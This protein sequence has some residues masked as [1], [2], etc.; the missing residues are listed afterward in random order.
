MIHNRIIRRQGGVAILTHTTRT[1]HRTTMVTQLIVIQSRIKNWSLLRGNITLNHHTN[2]IDNSTIIIA[3]I[4]ANGSKHN[5][6]KND[7]LS[8][9]LANNVVNGTL[10]RKLTSNRQIK[11]WVIIRLRTYRRHIRFIAT[12]RT[13]MTNINNLRFT[14]IIIFLNNMNTNRRSHVLRKN[15]NILHL[16]RVNIN[17]LIILGTQGRRGPSGG[18]GRHRRRGS[19]RRGFVTLYR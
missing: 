6:T 4:I 2:N 1:S 3:I 16:T 7:T 15:L 13:M 12:R 5:Y 11:L 10:N 8:N 17:L 19:M 9:I 14:P 18:R